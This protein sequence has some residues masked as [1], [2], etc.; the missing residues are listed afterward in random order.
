M[1]NDAHGRSGQ[2]IEIRYIVEE[3]IPAWGRALNLG[4]L[5]PHAGDGAEVRRRLFEPGRLQ[6][7]FDHSDD[8]RCVGTFR[9]FDTGLTVPGGAVIEVDAVTSVTVSTTHRR[10]GLLSGMMRRD[11]AAARERG[12]VAAILIAAE[13]N[14][15]GRY[16]FG[17]A[18]RRHGWQIDLGRAGGLRP[19]LPDSPGGRIGFVTMEELRRLGPELHERWQPTQPGAIGRSPIGWQFATGELVRPGTEWKEPFAVVHRNA[20]G[21]VTGLAVYHVDDVWDGNYPDC[22]LTVSDFLALDPGTAVALWRLLCSVD[23]V[24]RIVVLNL[25][26]DDPLPLLL[27]EP[28]A[29]T[30]HPENGDHTWLRLLDLPAAFAARTCAAPGRVVFQV[31]DPERYVE[32]RWA[33]EAGADGRGRCTPTEDEPDLALDA[34]ALASLYLGGETAPRLA[35]AGLVTELRPGG[36]AAAD[37]L[38]RTPLAP[39]N[40]DGF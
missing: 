7:A 26:P 13:Y 28:R 17:P 30:P 8:G 39:W 29:A 12:S 40:P 3:E 14:I 35:A 10:R 4:F 32:G 5:R 6:G 38:L 21:T 2:D 31:S 19:G 1:G 16:G 33:L 27:N 34:G 37:L 24:S 23:W 11:L 9:S 25:A 18:T 20:E 22:T 15:Y 36:V